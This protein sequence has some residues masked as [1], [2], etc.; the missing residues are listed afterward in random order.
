[1]KIIV[2]IIIL[3]CI[4][5]I[6]EMYQFEKEYKIINKLSINNGENI[7]YY[8]TIK[9]KSTN[10]IFKVRVNKETYDLYEINDHI[11]IL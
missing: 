5:L 4:F 10:S 11:I 6:Y 2:T 9:R 7:E 3:F 8:F 1:M